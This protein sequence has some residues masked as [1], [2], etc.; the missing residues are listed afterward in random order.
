L[1]G[2]FDSKCAFAGGCWTNDSDDGRFRGHAA[3]LRSR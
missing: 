3:I 2:D 1:E